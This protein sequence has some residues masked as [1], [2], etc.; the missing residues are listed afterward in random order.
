LFV[1]SHSVINPGLFLI[2]CTWLTWSE[3]AFLATGKL[4][5]VISEGT[6]KDVDL[7]VAAAQKAFETVWGLNTPGS[8]RGEAL[9]VLAQAM[10]RHKQELAAIEALDNGE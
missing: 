3:S 4:T 2:L 9:W 10:E 7:A 8:K 5:T 6:E 1:P